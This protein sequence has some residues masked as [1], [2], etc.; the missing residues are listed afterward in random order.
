MR[1]TERRI[2]QKINNRFYKTKAIDYESIAFCF[3]IVP[4]FMSEISG[5]LQDEPYWPLPWL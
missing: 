1:V 2:K 3:L 4:G 5:S